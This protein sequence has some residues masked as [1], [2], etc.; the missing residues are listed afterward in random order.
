ML[1]SIVYPFLKK[2][3][4]VLKN[5]ENMENVKRDNLK[6]IEAWI[7][8]LIFQSTSRQTARI[9]C[10]NLDFLPRVV[11]RDISSNLLSSAYRR[12]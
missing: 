2:I 9:P 8:G 12:L 7:F 1:L 11:I 5:L 6:G 3:L 4:K 10:N